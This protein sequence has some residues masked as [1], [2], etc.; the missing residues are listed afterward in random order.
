MKTKFYSVFNAKTKLILQN[1]TPLRF[2]VGC[3]CAFLISLFFIL[4]KNIAAQNPDPLPDLETERL[5]KFQ[6]SIPI[7]KANGEAYPMAWAGGLN[8]P[9]FSTLD[10]NGDGTEDLFVFDRT[11]RK[12]TTFLARQNPNTQNWE[13]D[14]APDYAHFF[15]NGSDW[16]LL[17]DFNC[18][19]K[20]DIF[21][22]VPFGIAVYKNIS[23]TQRL[24]FELFSP[25]LFTQG[26]TGRTN[27][28]I[29]RTDIPALVDIDDDGDLD[30]LNFQ[31]AV[32]GLVELQLNESR[33]RGF[34][35]DS[36]LFRKIIKWGDFVECDCETFVL[37]GSSN[38]RT[39]Q[40]AHA[41]STLL[42]FDANGDGKKDLLTGDVGCPNLSLLLNEGENVQA[43]MRRVIPNFPQTNPVNLSFFPAAFYQDVT[44][45]GKKDLL[46]SPNLYIN[47]LNLVDFER[48]IWLYENQSTSPNPNQNPQFSFISTQFL[49]EK[50][51]DLGED[52]RPFLVDIDGDGDKDLFVGVRGKLQNQNYRARLYFFEN[53][54]QGF[55]LKEEDFAAL[56]TQNLQFLKPTF[57]DIDQDGRADLFFT[58]FDTESRR[59]FLYYLNANFF[60]Q[61][62]NISQNLIK[63]ENSVVEI[64]ILDEPFLY[65]TDQDGD[66]DLL[67]GRF[68]G[69]IQVFEN[70]GVGSNSLP[71]W[72]AQTTAF[73]S[74]LL[75]RRTALAIGDLDGDLSDDLL[76]ADA[77][78]GLVLY[79]NL[80]SILE[81]PLADAQTWREA[82]VK[83]WLFH[84][85]TQSAVAP[86][87]GEGVFPALFGN[88]IFLGTIGGGLLHLQSSQAA[89][90]PPLPEGEL[91][92][93]PNPSSD[94]FRILSPK[95]ASVRVFNVLGQEITTFELLPNVAF[96]LQAQSWARGLYLMEVLSQEG[97]KKSHKILR[98]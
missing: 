20:P 27:L 86:F 42:V 70:Q 91:R 46:V 96:D 85:P 36:L 16:Y 65:D 31:P 9:Q 87:F 94:V 15:P 13:W 19:G 4:P 40:L 8:A 95:A 24:D 12:I 89:F 68:Q 60:N 44:F 92:I 76:V 71:Q 53:T 93:F 97:V 34:G 14:Y 61:T 49:Q 75:G 82:A 74:L 77:E 51:L 55:W 84:A 50:M 79:K 22:A 66:L 30:L 73:V 54:P 90:P 98:W 29:D 80:K 88:D 21:M 35:C 26:L 62:Q 6:D 81:N 58:A 45:D 43:Q 64:R 52:T 23:T 25:L 2:F 1:L 10:L 48:S 56:S 11:S 69:G 67:I 78:N 17:E 37:G 5:W 41:G 39:E 18:D 57:A 47:E 38:C 72:R 33:E 7:L 63:I 59:S 3:F 32:G 28:D 83:N